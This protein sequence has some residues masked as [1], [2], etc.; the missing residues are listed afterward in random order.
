MLI[1]TRR[2]GERIHIGNGIELEIIAVKGNRVRVG[3]RCPREVPIH[4][5]EVMDRLPLPTF[6]IELNDQLHAIAG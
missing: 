1:L 6:E 3:I 5:A 2:P 4:R